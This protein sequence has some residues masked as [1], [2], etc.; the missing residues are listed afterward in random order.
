MAHMTNCG[1]KASPRHEHLPGSI[2]AKASPS[3]MLRI[4]DVYPRSWNRLFSIPD[5]GPASNNLSILTQT[6][7]SKLSEI[8]SGL[9]IRDPDPG[10]E[11]RIQGSK[12]HRI[13]DP[14]HYPSPPIFWHHKAHPFPTL[15]ITSVGVA[16]QRSYVWWQNNFYA[17]ETHIM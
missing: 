17:P 16:N 3:P 5:L 14:Q 11:S 15:L 7:V 2:E 6:I 12:R 10:S 1:I 13:P 4:R 8:W 9:F